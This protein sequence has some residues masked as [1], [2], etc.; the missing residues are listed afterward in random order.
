[1]TEQV[2][3][4][5][6]S[7]L[8]PLGIRGLEERITSRE[9]RD[10]L[11]RL[12]LE[13]IE[14]HGEEVKPMAETGTDAELPL[15]IPGTAVLVRLGTPNQKELTALLTV[16]LALMG[17][18]QLEAKTVGLTALGAVLSRVQRAKTE[19]GERS[20]LEALAEL[21]KPTLQNVTLLL[22]GNPC[23]HPKAG[24]RF[25]SS[26]KTCSIMLE[27]VGLTIVAMEQRSMVRRRN[28]LE[29]YEYGV[30]F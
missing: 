27:Q 11:F 30:V 24:C 3:L 12:T 15:R 2:M 6:D 29:P 21:S 28:S 14:A 22:L 18:G 16:T 13:Y 8:R 7:F 5:A 17:S 20:I 26:D 9:Q 19:Y 23:R 4:A 1:M 10:A 25:M